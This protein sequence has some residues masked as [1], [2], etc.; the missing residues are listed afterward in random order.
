MSA[1]MVVSKKH[2]NK[3]LSSRYSEVP[4]P[5]A[6]GAPGGCAR[7]LRSV[8]EDSSIPLLPKFDHCESP[9]NNAKTL[10]RLIP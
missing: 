8:S 3:G 4:Y 2:N 1:D 6:S 5:K 10:C 7:R 9:S